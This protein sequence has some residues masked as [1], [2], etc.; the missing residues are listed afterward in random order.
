MKTII[1]CVSVMVTSLLA[2][3]SQA[4]YASLDQDMKKEAVLYRDEG[5]RFQQ[6]NKFDEAMGYYQKALYLDPQYAP[7]YNDMGIV[8]AT[9]GD[10]A[11]AE[12]HY[13]RAIAADSEYIPPYS[14]LSLLYEKRGDYYNALMY[15]KELISRSYGGKLSPYAR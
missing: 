11:R 4:A 7:A 6:Q 14:N 3:V 5:Y 9:M 8:F 2:C 15:L 10:D 13:L 1:V 12:E